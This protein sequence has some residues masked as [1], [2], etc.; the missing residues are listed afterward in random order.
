MKTSFRIGLVVLFVIISSCSSNKYDIDKANAKLIEIQKA[1]DTP[2]IA[3]TVSK[4]NKIIWS[5][6]F[7]LG[8]IEQQVPVS[9]EKTKF[10]IF[11]I[12]Y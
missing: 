3:I 12:I 11:I 5:K 7:G 10:R 1:D 6:G 9:P 8:N 2:G 4:D